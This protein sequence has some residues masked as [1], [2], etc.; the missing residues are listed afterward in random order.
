MPKSRKR[1][2]LLRIALLAGVLTIGL[3]VAAAHYISAMNQESAI[4]TTREWARLA[5]FPASAQHLRVETRGSMFTR[6]FVITFDAPAADVIKWLQNSPGP[7]STQPAAEGTTSVYEFTPGGG[8]NDA[9]VRYEPAT[10][11]VTIDTSWS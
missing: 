10:G 3:A 4:A 5:P 2:I 1:R 7:A 6:E 11:K 9:K 8:A